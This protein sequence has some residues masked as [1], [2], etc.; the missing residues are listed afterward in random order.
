MPER[1]FATHPY[2]NKYIAEDIR[3]SKV[4]H[5]PITLYPLAVYHNKTA[6]SRRTLQNY[7]KYFSISFKGINLSE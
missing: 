1:E 2:D 7:G 4:T 3:E 5:T 6:K